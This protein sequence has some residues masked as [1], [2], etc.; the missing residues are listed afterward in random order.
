MSDGLTLLLEAISQSIDRIS[1][2]V[3]ADDPY[4]KWMLWN[5]EKRIGYHRSES[6]QQVCFCWM[7]DPLT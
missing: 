2:F 1:I 5:E 7:S 4:Q 6:E 3:G